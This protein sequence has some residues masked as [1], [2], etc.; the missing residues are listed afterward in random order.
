M[1][2]KQLLDSATLV[3]TA[4]M[5]LALNVL[6]SELFGSARIDLTEDG[7]FTLSDGTRA[8]LESLDEPVT[9]HLFFSDKIATV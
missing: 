2:R 1:A 8:V 9:L 7:L 4:L 6:G 5:F 3:V